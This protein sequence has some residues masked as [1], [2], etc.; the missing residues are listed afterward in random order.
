MSYKIVKVL[1]LI[2][3]IESVLVITGWVLGIDWLTR[4]VPGGMNMKFITAFLFFVS[5]WGLLYMS[6]GISET[7]QVLL[8]GTALIIIL[9][10][11]VLLSGSLSGN[12]T[13]LEHLFVQDQYSANSLGSGSPS[14]FSIICFIIFGMA[15]VFFL[16]P[17]GRGLR[18]F[19]GYPIV[20]IGFIAVLGHLIQMPALYYV[21]NDSMV[22]MAINTAIA[23]VLLGGGLIINDLT[24][25]PN[26]A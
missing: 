5:G 20:I 18:K 21:F 23:F 25:N 15:G 17:K 4:M 19:F 16:F 3:I 1:A 6:G 7:D 24:K 10:S 13:G 2:I 9:V 22:P 26:E 8:P 14:L 12:Q 11:A